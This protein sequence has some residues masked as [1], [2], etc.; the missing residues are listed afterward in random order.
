[1][2]PSSDSSEQQHQTKVPLLDMLDLD[3]TSDAAQ[4]DTTAEIESHLVTGT[5][6]D[7]G[8][9]DLEA[10][11]RIA[12]RVL[13]DEGAPA[14]QL[15]LH[16]VDRDTIRELNHAHMDSDEPTDV[17]AF[18]LDPDEFDPSG[19][20]DTPALLGDVVVCPA[21]AFEQAPGHSGS[22]EAEMA[23]LTIH[24]TL[25]ILGHDHGETGER[26][27]MQA[28]ERHHLERLDH[29]HPVPAP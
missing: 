15:D 12:A 23:L 18:P 11:C 13:A 7:G 17:L 27:T 1:M 25:H 3:S 16:L 26:L 19:I 28:R 21:V 22:F 4:P 24:G 20:G 29:A 10:L 8:R 9:V 5:N 14:G 2:S 6:A